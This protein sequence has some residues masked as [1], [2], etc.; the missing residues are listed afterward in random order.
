MS[1]YPE[2]SFNDN[3]QDLLDLS[4]DTGDLHTM[5]AENPQRCARIAI[6]AAQ[7]DLDYRMAKFAHEVAVAQFGEQCKI[8][9]PKMSE[10][11]IT[12]NAVLDPNVADA[13]AV[14]A[15]CEAQ[16][17]LWNNIHTS[18]LQRRSSIETL[19]DLQHQGA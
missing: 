7:A 10:A 11:A 9:D 3:E 17:N 18:A 1:E 12:R 16:R 5:A 15:Q 19:N 8:N 13:F 14:F 4:I 6:K 2:L